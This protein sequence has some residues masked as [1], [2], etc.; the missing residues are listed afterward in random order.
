MRPLSALLD[1]FRRGVAVPA[2]LGD[3]LAAELAPVFASLELFEAEAEDLRRAYERQAEDRLAEARE[4]A[5][6]I[7]AG[8]QARASAARA[9]AAEERWRRAREEA[10][11]IVEAGRIEGERIRDEAEGRMPAFVASIVADV[12]REPS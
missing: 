12:A 4:Q 9:S 6:R 10:A 7:T 3:E 1:R 2:A 5:A 11:A 8:V